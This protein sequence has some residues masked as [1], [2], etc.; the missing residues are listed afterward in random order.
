MF[1]KL[2]SQWMSMYEAAAKV[3]LV[4][5]EMENEKKNITNYSP[6]DFDYNSLI[7]KPDMEVS[8]VLKENE[9]ARRA[10][11]KMGRTVI[12]KVATQGLDRIKDGVWSVHNKDIDDIFIIDNP[13]LEHSCNDNESAQ[14]TM[15]IKE[16]AKNA[17]RVNELGQKGKESGSELYISYA[18]Y[19]DGN[20]YMVRLTVTIKKNKYG[21]SRICTE[22]RASKIGSGPK[23]ISGDKSVPDALPKVRLVK[24]YRVSK[25]ILQL[26][27]LYLM[28]F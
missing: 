6:K 5:Q 14:A 18:E 2:H 7:N 20:A 8:K 28:M 16:I 1:E 11:G 15:N 12:K 9:I 10:D 4:Q 24:Y 27:R 22:I 3:A 19:E 23:D 17:I 25:I 21:K 26:M 13:C